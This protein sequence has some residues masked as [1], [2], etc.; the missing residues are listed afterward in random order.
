MYLVYA[1]TLLHFIIKVI[2]LNPLISRLLIN[3][4]FGLLRQFVALPTISRLLDFLIESRSVL[5]QGDTSMASH[6]SLM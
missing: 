4:R 2:T 5:G 6:S 3:K 1:C